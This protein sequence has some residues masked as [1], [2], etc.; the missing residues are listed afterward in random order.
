MDSY[1]STQKGTFE[2]K[3]EEFTVAKN[4]TCATS[5]QISPAGAKVSAA[6]DI[7]GVKDAYP[8]L[9]C[10]ASLALSG[11]Q[12]YHHFLGQ[13][14][15]AYRLRLQADF[16]AHLYLTQKSA[17]GDATK[18]AAECSSGGVQGDYWGA[19]APG[20]WVSG[21][22]T[23]AAGIDYMVGV[24]STVAPAAG[25]FK[26]QLAELP[27]AKNEACSGAVPLTLSSGQ[28]RVSGDTF[29]RKDEHATLKCG[30][31]TALS[32]PQLYYS[33]KAAVSKVYRV[34]L[35]PQFKGQ[36][37]IFPKAACGSVTTV[38]AACASKG[39]AGPLLSSPISP[40]SGGELLFSPA[41]AGDHIIA[42]D[43]GGSTEAGAFDLTVSEM[44]LPMINTF[45]APIS[46][47][48]EQSCQNLLASGDWECGSLDFAASPACGKG[49][50]PPSVGHTGKG[51]WGTR[52]N[53]CYAARGNNAHTSCKAASSA[54][55]SKL[56][57]QVA[58]PSTWTKATL[59]YWAW[60]DS[61][62]PDD[63]SEV[64]LDDVPVPAT[65]T[66]NLG[67]YSAPTAWVQHTVDL[68]AKLGKSVLVSFHFSADT[69]SN[70]AGLYLDDI[71]VSGK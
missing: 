30:G 27:P 23:K 24:E 31:A 42:V 60:D 5:L 11:P 35:F 65:Q 66:C 56:S 2:L 51:V 38:E 67:S 49:A 37:Y 15:N 69:S 59:T 62:T 46:W 63:W 12:L 71:S 52:L 28:A 68:T 39:K 43:S 21:Y 1:T 22:F 70:L 4:G 33:F 9:K 48:F 26:L 55:D 45:N 36:L 58:L 18:M 20:G 17:C 41:T 57:F 44:F 3:V 32:G 34:A 6:G 10:G 16:A 61:H 47:D 8:G 29:V 50:A 25:T 14:N 54:D 40:F 7:S 13:K 19:A 64:R 53:D